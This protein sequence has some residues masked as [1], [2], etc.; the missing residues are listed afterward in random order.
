MEIAFL[1]LF[2]FT[3]DSVRV[4]IRLHPS[5]QG[6]LNKELVNCS[7]VVKCSLKFT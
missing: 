4:E 5:I 7:F 1:V 6:E 2:Y 3:V